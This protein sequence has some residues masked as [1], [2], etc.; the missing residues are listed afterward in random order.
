MAEAAAG[1]TLVIGHEPTM[2]EAVELSATREATK[3]WA[4]FDLKY[5]TSAMATVEA[6]SAEDLVAGRG[7][8]VDFV[9]P[10]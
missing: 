1:T 5:P 3:A 9:I 10:R 8:L 7:R 6:P 2:G 4:A